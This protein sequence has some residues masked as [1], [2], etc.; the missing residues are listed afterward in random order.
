MSNLFRINVL[1][2]NHKP[3]VEKQFDPFESYLNE[4]S[5]I[6]NIIPF[7][8]KSAIEQWASKNI[9]NVFIAP[10]LDGTGLTLSATLKKIFPKLFII[11]F[12]HTACNSPAVRQ[13]C[14]D[15]GANMVT[16]DAVSMRS[17]VTDVWNILKLPGK[18]ICPRCGENLTEDA[19]W[20]HD[21]RYHPND[22]NISV[23]CPICKEKPRDNY[24]VHLHCEHG[25]IGR[26]EI[27]GEDHAPT[28]LYGFGLVICRNP[29]T[30]KYLVVQEYANCGFWVPGGRVDPGEQFQTVTHFIVC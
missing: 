26:G 24:T 3:V 13:R 12:S 6:C 11:I 28:K 15:S 27:K 30:K 1:I 5:L 8:D 20:L 2:L 4:L 25:P 14:F 18:Y 22:K 21:S 10:L 16:M 19:L 23:N 7:D 9:P 17:V 29:V